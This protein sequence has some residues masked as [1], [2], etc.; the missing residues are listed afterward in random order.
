MQVVLLRSS[1]DKTVYGKLGEDELDGPPWWTQIVLDE[2]AT[3]SRRIKRMESELE[4]KLAAFVFQSHSEI[5]LK[6]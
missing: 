1:L 6:I 3:L 5:M 4:V 2:L